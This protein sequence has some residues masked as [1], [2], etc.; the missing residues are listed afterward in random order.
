MR[1]RLVII[2][3]DPTHDYALEQTRQLDT[4]KMEAFL[5]LNDIVVL[6]L[7]V[8]CITFTPV[9][10]LCF[11]NAAKGSEYQ[12]GIGMMVGGLISGVL[13]WFQ[14]RLYLS[15]ITMTGLLSLAIT[16]T[17]SIGLHLLQPQPQN[18]LPIAGKLCL[19]GFI[20]MWIGVVS[21]PFRVALQAWTWHRQGIDLRHLRDEIRRRRASANVKAP[22]KLPRGGT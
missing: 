6:F 10:L 15:A 14:T 8:S 2:K 21:L 20:A 13:A 18:P 11:V 1:Q 17:V 12:L 4:L 19:F 22:P 16:V 5:K 3:P 7:T 9:G